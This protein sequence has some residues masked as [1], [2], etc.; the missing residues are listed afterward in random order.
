MHPDNI[1]LVDC[2]SGY[3]VYRNKEEAKLLLILEN[4]GHTRI[5]RP[6]LGPRLYCWTYDF[7]EFW[8]L[9]HK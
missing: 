1:R 2:I 5:G 9:S 3:K 4:N 7:L 6:L 8:N